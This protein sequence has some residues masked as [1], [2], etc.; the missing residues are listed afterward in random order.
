MAVASAQL[1]MPFAPATSYHAEDFIRGDSNAAA[2]DLMER[3]PNWP[4]SLVVVHGPQGCGKTHLAHVFAKVSGA[5]FIDPARIGTIPADAL[6]AGGHSWILDGL[7]KVASEDGLAQFI[8]HARARGDY[9]LMCARQAP[10]QLPFRLNDL[11]S[12]LIA[13]PEVALGAPDDALLMGVLA[14]AFADRQL[15]VGPEVL[16]YAVSR[17]ERSYESVQHF[18]ARVDRESLAAGRA[19]TLP[20]VRAMLQ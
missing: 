4:Y 14:K 11:R 6:L 19:V 3:W 9:V 12:R 16:Q 17:L 10:S 13:L 2:F 5:Q 15:R 7:E 20:W 1:V 8:N 18:A